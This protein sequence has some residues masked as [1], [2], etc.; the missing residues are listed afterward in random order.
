METRLFQSVKRQLALVF[1]LATATV[2]S[3]TEDQIIFLDSLER[4]TTEATAD[5][6]RVIV[7]FY[8]PKND[9]KVNDFYVSGARKMTGAYSNKF[10]RYK[11]GPF[12]TYYENGNLES[13]VTFE[14]NLPI[15]KCYFWYENGSKKAECEVYKQRSDNDPLLRVNQFWSRIG[16]QRVVNGKGHYTDEDITSFSEGELEKGLKQG[17]WWGTDY[18]DN[19]TFV[20][21]Y[22]K[23]R[24]VSGVATDS[25]NQTHKYNKVFIPAEPK[26]GYDHFDRYFQSALE[27]NKDLTTAEYITVGISFTVRSDGKITDFVLE[28]DNAKTQEAMRKI[29]ER[30]GPWLPAQSRGIDTDTFL[31]VPISINRY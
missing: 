29:V 17:Q 9:C 2:Q 20:E 25:L 7:D 22:K 16:I 26:K 11:T 5:F 21:T 13:Q 8:G 27:S 23:G 14:D 30:Y 10:S 4:P 28:Y 3:Q 15:G 18:K 24:L 6:V 1:V 19:F 12:L 31:S